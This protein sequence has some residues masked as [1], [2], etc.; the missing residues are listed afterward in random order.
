MYFGPSPCSSLLK[1]SE[2]TQSLGTNS[3]HEKIDFVIKKKSGFEEKEYQT[4][5]QDDVHSVSTKSDTVT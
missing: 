4:M 5:E 3:C 2:K 1:I